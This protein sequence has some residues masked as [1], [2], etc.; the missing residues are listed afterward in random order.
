MRLS[1]YMHFKPITILIR[2]FQILNNRGVFVNSEINSEIL[3]IKNGR[4]K[5]YLGRLAFYPQSY[6][7]ACQSGSPYKPLFDQM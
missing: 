6:G 1:Y 4:E 5:F 7:I 3:A 2:F